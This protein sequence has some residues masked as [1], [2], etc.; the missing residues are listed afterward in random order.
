MANQSEDKVIGEKS[1]PARESFFKSGVDAP[2][3]KAKRSLLQS[4]LQVK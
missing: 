2:H 3:S 4:I 1:K